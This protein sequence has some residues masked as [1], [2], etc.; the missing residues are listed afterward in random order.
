MKIQAKLIRRN[1]G[2]DATLENVLWYSSAITNLTYPNHV[3][4][5]AI[6]YGMSM[7]SV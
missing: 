3:L 5:L 7:R 2:T 1:K 4:L 6:E